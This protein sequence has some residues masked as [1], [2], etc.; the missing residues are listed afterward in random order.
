MTPKVHLWYTIHLQACFDRI[1]K[2]LYRLSG[3]R[4]FITHYANNIWNNSRFYTDFLVIGS[5][6]IL[7]IIPT[8]FEIKQSTLLKFLWFYW[9]RIFMIYFQQRAN[10]KCILYNSVYIFI[11]NVFQASYQQ[12]TTKSSTKIV[13]DK[14]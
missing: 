12:P 4:K 14:L 11:A 13:L 5:T 8:I 6:I 2:I 3:Y 7:P 1:L 9:V 10:K